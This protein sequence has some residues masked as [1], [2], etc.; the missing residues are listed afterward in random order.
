VRHLVL[1]QV[2]KKLSGI[3]K[4]KKVIVNSIVNKALTNQILKKRVE[5]HGNDMS[6][7]VTG[8]KGLGSQIDLPVL[9]WKGVQVNKSHKNK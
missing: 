8:V 6:R 1:R 4:A 7:R 5:N 3:K 2:R 9:V